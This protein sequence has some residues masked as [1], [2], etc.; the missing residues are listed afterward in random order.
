MV[1]IAG[2]IVTEMQDNAL[3]SSFK[4]SYRSNCRASIG[5]RDYRYEIVEPR[6]IVESFFMK[7]FVSKECDARREVISCDFYSPTCKF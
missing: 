1:E 2:K 6:L 5:S 4:V 7:L 3:E